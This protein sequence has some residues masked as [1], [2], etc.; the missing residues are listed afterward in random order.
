MTSPD[1]AAVEATRQITPDLSADAIARIITD[2]YA[3]ERF[4]GP[5][6]PQARLK[7]ICEF[8]II[9]CGANRNAAP[10]PEQSIYREIKRLRQALTTER[11]VRERLVEAL[12]RSWSWSGNSIPG[13]LKSECIARGLSDAALASAEKLEDDDV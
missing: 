11:V 1:E 12:K 6:T 2:C 4:N 8:A 9:H 5:G 10:P 13:P 3:E 7:A